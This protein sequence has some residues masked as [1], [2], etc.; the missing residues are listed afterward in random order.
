[1]SSTN[2]NLSPRKAKATSS[3][4]YSNIIT[5]PCEKVLMILRQIKKFILNISKDQ[6]KLIQNLDWCIKIITSRSLYSYELKEKDNINNLSKANPEFK[7]LVDFVSEYNEKVIKMNRQYDFILTDKLL[8]KSSTK[9]NRRQIERKS[10]YGVKDS[11]IFQLLLDET[12]KENKNEKKFFNSSKNKDVGLSKKKISRNSVFNP[13]LNFNAITTILNDKYLRTEINPFDD[14]FVKKKIN[15]KKVKK[16]LININD[17]DKL[18]SNAMNG[19]NDSIANMT[20]PRI[21]QTN[22]I[23]HESTN[24]ECLKRMNNANKTKLLN[25]SNKKT[26]NKMEI[27]PSVK[28]ISISIN[29]GNTS[30]DKNEKT[31]SS[32]T[33]IRNP[34]KR[35]NSTNVSNLRA[36]SSVV[37]ANS[38]FKKNSKSKKNISNVI[39]G[40]D[41]SKLQNKLIHEG[42]D[43][44]KLVTEK[45]FN[46][47][48]LKDLIGYNNVLPIMG[49]VI[50]E[51]LG[52]LDEEILNTAKLDKF[53]ISV[54]NQ[55][56]QEILYHNAL[57][58]S[59]V[60]HSVYIFFTHSNAEKLAKTNVL[61]LLSIIIAALGHD[62]GHPGLTN[63]YQINGSTDMAIIYNDISVLENFHASTLFRTIRKTD[64]NV[65]EKLTKID[66]KLIRKRM[67]SEILATD[68]ANHVKVISLIKSKISLNEENK[69]L[70]ECKLTL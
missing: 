13:D 23:Q 9:L 30:N 29:K 10:S 32:Y 58:G 45:H 44:S 15:P 64:C 62:I 49:R 41:F 3:K 6:S 28:T 43:I 17:D 22:N 63:T 40:Y 38:K 50:L 27:F 54:S 70:N 20:S 42:F 11:K 36:T 7:Q 55:Y 57:H 66:Y 25:Y 53:L 5:T 47:F 1:M 16:Q 65:F 34:P 67:I 37:N 2:R 12:N 21:Y 31:I 68:M 69:N 35:F 39:K 56:K 48:E 24:V 18:L 33:Q 61:D 26:R 60:T 4:L 52:L 14:A 59:D 19:T 51:K 8:Q 46:I